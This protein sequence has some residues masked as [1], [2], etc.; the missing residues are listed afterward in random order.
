MLMKS[1]AEVIKNTLNYVLSHKECQ[2]EDE[3]FDKWCDKVITALENAKK[4]IV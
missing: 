3:E 1:F 4:E 2:T